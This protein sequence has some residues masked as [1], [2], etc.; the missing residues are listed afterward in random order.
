MLDTGFWI[1]DTGCGCPADI[2]QQAGLGSGCGGFADTK[3]KA[4]LDEEAGM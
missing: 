1:L 4:W 3:P 2:P